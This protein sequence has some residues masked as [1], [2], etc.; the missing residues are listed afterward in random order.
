MPNTLRVVRPLEKFTQCDSGNLIAQQNLSEKIKPFLSL[1]LIGAGQASDL[2]QDDL[3]YASGRATITYVISG[4]AVYADSTGKRG[5]LKQGGLSW[6]LSGA[7]A[8]SQ[9]TPA[10][11][12]YLA[13]ELSVALAPALEN[14]PT[15]SAWLDANLIERDG[16]AGL[17]VGW[18]G[19]NKGNFTLPSLMNYALV[20]LRARQDWSYELPANHRVVWVF[21]ISGALMA[22]EGEIAANQIRVLDG[23]SGKIKVRATAGS[24]FVVGSSQEFAHDLIAHK[25]SVHTS[26]DALQLGLDRLAELEVSLGL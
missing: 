21:V 7:G 17:L 2:Q 18:F 23:S 24:L 3:V 14:S 12:N 10:T 20:N 13:L 16:P 6:V 26:T 11:N 9:I 15:Q 4:Q 5:L 8:W 19:E 22:A 25:N 1:K